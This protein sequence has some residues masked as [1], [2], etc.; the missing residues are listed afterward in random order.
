MRSP[1]GGFIWVGG[2][3]AFWQFVRLIKVAVESGWFL[4][5]L[6]FFVHVLLRK[7]LN[8]QNARL[9]NINI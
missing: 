6:F 9:K 2:C 8:F 5:S 3:L 7:S 1:S 4:R